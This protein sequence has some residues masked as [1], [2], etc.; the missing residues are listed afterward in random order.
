[1]ALVFFPTKQIVSSVTRLKKFEALLKFLGSKPSKTEEKH[2]LPNP[3]FSSVLSGN[4]E[5][6]FVLLFSNVLF[7]TDFWNKYPTND[8]AGVRQNMDIDRQEMDRNFIMGIRNATWSK[9]TY[10]VIVFKN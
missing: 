9:I 5:I 10:F 2:L 1:M 7:V 8:E 3:E 4:F 6:S